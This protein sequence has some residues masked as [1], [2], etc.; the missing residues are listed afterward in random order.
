MSKMFEYDTFEDYWNNLS[1]DK[2]EEIINGFE[3][4]N[5]KEY[6]DQQKEIYTFFKLQKYSK[7]D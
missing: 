2:K 7:E 3:L 5:F 4:D 1:N 6:W